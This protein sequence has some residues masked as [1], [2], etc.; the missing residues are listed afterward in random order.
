MKGAIAMTVMTSAPPLPAI[1]PPFPV[2]RFTVDEYHQMIRTGIITEDDDVELL[3]RWIVPKMG[4]S[5]SHDAVISWIM[6]RRFIPTLPE[7]WFCRGRSAIATA[8]SEPEPDISVVRGSELDYLERHPG[9]ADMAL[10][11]EVADSTLACDQVHKAQIYSSAAVPVYWI[12]NLVDD[13]VE[14]YSDPTGPV[15]APVYRT[16]R[17]YKGSELIPFVLDGRELGP[18]A[19]QELLP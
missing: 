19:A 18:I 1:V 12:S 15:P 17:D 11:I 2:R 13:Q 5:P 8:H 4:I 3:E 16:R 14:V 7:G 6:N 9:S 10:E